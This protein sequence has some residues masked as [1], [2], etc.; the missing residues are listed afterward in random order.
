ME[1][2]KKTTSAATEVE[3]KDLGKLVNE[4]AT[5]VNTGQIT[6]NQMM[7]RLGLEPIGPDGDRVIIL[8]K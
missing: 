3:T 5:K 4:L 6:P 2:N 7:V 1:E 8:I